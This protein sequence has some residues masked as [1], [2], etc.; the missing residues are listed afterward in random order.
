MSSFLK[1]IFVWLIFLFFTEMM[2]RDIY[3]VKKTL[4]YFDY[5]IFFSKKSLT[6]YEI[7]AF[8]DTLQNGEPVDDEVKDPDY[9]PPSTKD[10]MEE[11]DN[12]S[13]ISS[14]SNH[15]EEDYEEEEEDAYRTLQ[16]EIRIY[17]LPP[18]E[19]NDAESD[20][21]SGNIFFIIKTSH[22]KIP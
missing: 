18:V 1:P 2:S 11:D 16:T 7:S 9:A 12:D 20:H 13:D 8:L 4:F 6:T 21:D 14:S 10:I 22:K 15:E 3:S 19:R 5:F 17:M